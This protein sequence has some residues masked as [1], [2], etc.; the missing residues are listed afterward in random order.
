MFGFLYLAYKILSVEVMYKINTLVSWIIKSRHSMMT[1]K[2]GTIKETVNRKLNEGD[3]SFL[4]FL[5]VIKQ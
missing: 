2:G 4:L 5:I 3:L 1:I